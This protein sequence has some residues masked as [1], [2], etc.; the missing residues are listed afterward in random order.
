V[1]VSELG[2]VATAFWR[3]ALA[4]LPLGIAF[5]HQRAGDQPVR[6]PQRV[7]EHLAVAAPGV[8]L[9]ADLAAWHVSLHLTSVA[10]STVLANLAPV[11]VTLF[12]WLMLRQKPGRVFL[13]ALTLSSI[14]IV[15]LTG[16]RAALGSRD[17]GGE[18]MAL[19]SAAFY[20]GY[21][22]ALSRARVR[23]TTTT[24][25]FWTTGSAALCTGVLSWTIE[26]ALLPWSLAGWLTLCALGWVSQAGG[27]SLIAFALA[28]LSVT[29]SSLTLLIQPVVASVLAWLLLREP[30]AARQ[31]VGGFIVIAGITLARLRR[32][33]NHSS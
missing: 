24:I 25:M 13:F 17:I 18:A 14:G 8:F 20:A 4:L 26:P 30:L 5:A 33:T 31:I 22:L 12:S 9:A 21:I 15:I 11:F 6:L 28:W 2:P 19:A 7:S 27:Q 1:R 10:N 3:L 32:P 23:Y 29:L 16:G